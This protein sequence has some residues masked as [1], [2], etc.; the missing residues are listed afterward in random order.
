MFSRL[1]QG[2]T[3]VLQELSG[4]EQHGDDADPQV[5]LDTCAVLRNWRD[6]AHTHT[7]LFSQMFLQQ[8]LLF[9]NIRQG[10]GFRQL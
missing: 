6:C 7:H 3:S 8:E 1:T 5:S 9:F 10:S 2:V 4:E